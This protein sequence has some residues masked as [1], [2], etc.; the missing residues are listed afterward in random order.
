MDKAGI[1]ASQDVASLHLTL[2]QLQLGRELVQSL[3]KLSGMMQVMERVFTLNVFCVI[4]YQWV[5]SS[6]SFCAVSITVI[7]WADCRS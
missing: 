4:V 7:H 3:K 6:I 1:V 5:L 2:L